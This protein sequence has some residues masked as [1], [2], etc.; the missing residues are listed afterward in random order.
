[1]TNGEGMTV[2][3]AIVLAGR[4]PGTFP[5]DE[6]LLTL[7]GS[8]LILRA[9]DAARLAAPRQ[10]VAVCA[11]DRLDLGD[12]A[13]VEQV[14]HACPAESALAGIAACLRRFREPL[15]VIPA[16]AA[17]PRAQVAEEL[18]KLAAPD[19]DVALPVAEGVARPLF[20]VY[21]QRCRPVLERVLAGGGDVSEALPDLAV[22]TV[23]FTDA[24]P[25][26]IIA[27]PEDWE[28]ARRDVAP[29]AADQPALVA[30]VA[31]SGSGKTTFIEKLLP[32]L[33]RLGLRVGTV[34][35]DAHDFQIDYPG[36]DT[37]RHGAAGAE[38]Y[39]ISSAHRLAYVARQDHEISLPDLV[40]RFHA[41]RDL[42][43]VEGYKREAPHKMELFRKG[44]GH[45][46]PL[47][48]PSETIALITDENALRHPV[49]FG[50]DDAAALAAF[51]VTR[52]ETL[53]RY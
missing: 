25:F 47:Y 3:R 36:K 31:K 30:I 27:T 46:A 2:S 8:P 43:L 35:H 29:L 24:A 42:V 34:K 22:R 41:G 11:G 4:R 10:A 18:I 40:R 20:A 21:H 39:V 15:L 49:R 51:L 53:R 19:D 12:A 38:A 52:L 48:G 13:G 45:P 28:A 1:M 7:G 6:R 9:L 16:G 23:R 33:V 26:Q 50:L 5:V 17:R 14:E 44:A 32:E 37:Y